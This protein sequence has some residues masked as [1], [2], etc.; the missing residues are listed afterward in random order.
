MRLLTRLLAA[1]LA[2]VSLTAGPADFGQQEFRAALA[3][4]GLTISV[5]TE[6]NLDPPET[7]HITVRSPTLVRISGG[8]LRGLMYGLI[9]AAEQLREKGALSTT[10]G[11][12]G[13][14]LRA[15]RIA[16]S[17]AELGAPNFY[18]LDRWTTFFR[19]LA[20]HRV[21]RVTLVLPPA[22]FEADRLRTLSQIAH[23]H[24]V[25]LVLGVRGPLGDRL[26]YTQLRRIL[27]QCVLIRGVQVE[28]DREPV[29]YFRSIVFPALQEAG[30]RV[31]LDLRGAEARPDV[32]RAAV[33]AGVTLSVASRTAAGALNRAFHSVADAASVV[34][35]TDPVRARIAALATAGATGFELNL[36]GPNIETYERVY[37]AWGCQG[38]AYRSPSLTTGKAKAKAATKK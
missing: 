36:P 29:D 26:L 7:F 14:A 15:V 38:Y 30:R 25:D 17:D 11:A 8:D 18:S 6:L 22:R 2:C 19:M 34:P 32:L 3:E 13:M 24:A 10:Q 1:A 28:A 9:E 37:W 4:R 5:E 27:D 23:E 16:P 20:R 31:T 33:A 21:N 12:P 35:D